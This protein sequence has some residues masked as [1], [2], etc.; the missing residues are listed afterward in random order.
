MTVATSANL[1]RLDGPASTLVIDP[2][3]GT[4]EA[5]RLPRIAYW[6]AALP[7]GIDLAGLSDGL[8]RQG[9]VQNTDG[10][11]GLDLL[12]VAGFGS[13]ARPALEGHRAGHDWAPCFAV[14][15]IA[16]D[17]ATIEIKA[18]DKRA[19]LAI[20]LRLAITPGTDTLVRT[21]RV[22]NTGSAP[23]SLDWCAAG[24][25]ALP[26]ECR[27]VMGFEGRW[28]GE[29]QERRHT[30]HV[31]LWQRENRRGRS[32]H[33]TWPVL[34]AGTPGFSEESGTVYGFSLG[35]AGNNRL[36]VEETTDAERQVQMGELFFPGEMT[37]APGA[38]YDSPPLHAAFS[39]HGLNGLSQSFH[40]HV[41]KSVLDW[42]GGSMSPRKVHFNTWEGTYFDHSMARLKSQAEGAARLGAERFV[43]DDGWFPGRHDDTAALGDWWPDP[44]KYPE[45]LGPLIAHVESLGMEFGLWV[46]P[47]MVNPV[48]QLYSAHP[49]WCLHLEGYDRPTGR[50]QLV[51]DMGRA[52]VRDYLFEKLDAVLAANPGI[53]YLKWDMNREL[54]PGGSAGRPAYHAFVLGLYDLID[55]LRAAH[56]HVEIESCSSGGGRADLGILSRT[57]RVWTSDSNDPL[58]RQRIQ[59]GIAR[60]L[61]PEIMG[62]HVGPSPVH[63]SLR[64]PSMQLRAATAFFGHYG[65][66]L[67]PDL[68]PAEEEEV[69]KAYVAHYKR[70]R[71]TLHGGTSWRLDGM[72]E[73]RYGYGVVA[74]DKK[75]A[76]YTL[77][78]AAASPQRINPPLRFLGLDPA[79][80]YRV[81]LLAPLP[82]LPG[83]R[84]LDDLPHWA[85]L[86]GDGAVLNG[87]ALGLA[88]LILPS[89]WPE[90]A[91]ILEL[92]TV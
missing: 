22:T 48:S 70:L 46:E 60:L 42:P 57:H 40:T 9:R 35:W 27:E 63:S 32:G 18:E 82:Q 4:P 72:G 73:G 24:S 16:A 67:D 49:D 14:T 62:A 6:G 81:K 89:L 43:L 1:P 26:L 71:G 75:S 78:Q 10:W 87:A 45:G 36:L 65:M 77:V 8:K 17:S 28:I 61:P 13:A 85:G 31:G 55:R 58:E 3:P 19:G 34:I 84:S 56:P 50:N 11:I 44:E 39:A 69:L 51:L 25:F 80:D 15:G 53:R 38:S 33:E 64:Q 59:Q 66:E 47:E 30:A 79:R 88:G 52:D 86:T 91:L 7:A 41:R 74:A 20:T 83:N 12:P 90:T 68:V 5:A 2:R 54:F 23:Y 92:Q 37:L 76:V 21:S 29:F